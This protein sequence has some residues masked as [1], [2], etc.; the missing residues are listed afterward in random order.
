[1]TSSPANV[2]NPRWPYSKIYTFYFNSSFPNIFML[3]LFYLKHQTNEPDWKLGLKCAT[4]CCIDNVC[5][6]SS[7]IAQDCIDINISII[8]YIS[9]NDR[10]SDHTICVWDGNRTMKTLFRAFKNHTH[11]KNISETRLNFK[12]ELRTFILLNLHIVFLYFIAF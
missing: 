12:I 2:F 11:F 5:S 3:Q 1:M 4:H 10:F 8:I 6:L 9:V 7:V